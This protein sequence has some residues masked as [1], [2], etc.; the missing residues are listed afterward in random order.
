MT[1]LK[2]MIV[3]DNTT[4]AEDCR[5][6]LENVGHQVTSI[7]ATGEE[8][9]EAAATDSPDA[10]L[11]DIKLR[12]EMDGI[13]A[14]SKIYNQYEIP[15]LFLSAYSDNELL[16]RAKESGSFGYLVKPF[17]ERTL[18][19]MLEMTIYKSRVEKERR[20]MRARLHQLKKM[21]AMSVMAG[22]VAHNFNNK[23]TVV[24]GNL[25]LALDDLSPDDP[26]Y[27]SV[28][29]ALKA[30]EESAETSRLML[31]FIGSKMAEKKPLD[32][33]KTC[34]GWL[35][36]NRGAIPENI[37]LDMD[38]ATPGP[39]IMANQ[40]QIEE[41]LKAL[42]ANAWQAIEADS[43]GRVSVTVDAREAPQQLDI[44]TFPPDWRFTG[45]TCAC[46]EVADNGRGMNPEM[47]DKIFDPF[48]SS[49][50]INNKGL[51]L[52]VVWGNL[53]AHDGYIMVESAP[54]QG[55]V[56]TLFFPLLSREDG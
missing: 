3:E 43:A 32:L 44:F 26:A 54:G 40:E 8:A 9:I 51:G 49:D 27:P 48:Y 36:N 17:E 35:E 11:M 38:I 23:L 13:Q 46:L 55:S 28:E 14:A 34:K 39:L 19:A 1:A 42:V 15:V 7:Q 25:D 56:F 33:G 37:T 2:I 10:V 24:I 12:G 41:L 31:T 5:E 30:A 22:G 18:F 53:K 50:W 16:Q 45:E 29:G 21:E 4:V 52:C 47:I 20:Q 6:C